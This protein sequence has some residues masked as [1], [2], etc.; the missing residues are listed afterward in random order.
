M[1]EVFWS[2]LSRTGD[3]RAI[4]DDASTTPGRLHMLSLLAA[5]GAALLGLVGSLTLAAAQDSVGTIGH[6]TAPAI[7]DAQRIHESLADADRSSA[8]AFLTVGTG[9][10]GPL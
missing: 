9:A 5:G 8:N 3:R 2:R 7:I 10:P 4:R 6:R 1:M